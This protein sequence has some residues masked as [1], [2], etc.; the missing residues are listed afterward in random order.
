MF[1]YSSLGKSDFQASLGIFSV[2]SSCKG[3]SLCTCSI[4][5]SLAEIKKRKSSISSLLCK[6]L[7][8]L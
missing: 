7:F 4:I 3:N 1:S 5:L 8:G 6:H 2:I